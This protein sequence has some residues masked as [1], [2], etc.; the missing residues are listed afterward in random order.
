M[1]RAQK[2]MGFGRP[3]GTDGFDY[4]YR[5]TVDQRYQKVALRKAQ[6]YRL[7]TAQVAC[8]ALA[9]L[10]VALVMLKGREVSKIVFISITSGIIAIICGEIGRRRT[11]SMLLKLYIFASSF[12]TALSVSCGSSGHLSAH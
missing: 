10:W 2:G 5:M 3:L 1:E 7:Y 4:S 8:Q 11:S 6:L 9:L 12:A